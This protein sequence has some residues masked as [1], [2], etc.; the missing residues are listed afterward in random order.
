MNPLRLTVSQ[1]RVAA[2]CP[3][4]AYF[5][6]ELNRTKKL[7]PPSVTRLWKTG[8]D[9]SPET[10]ALG[11]LFH[12]TI[13]RFNREAPRDPRLA[14]ILKGAEGATRLEQELQSLIYRHYLK[15]ESLF[16]AGPKQQ[17]A[18]I[19]VLRTYVSEL[20]A[21][22]AYRLDQQVS[23]S[24]VL[25]QLFGDARRKVDVT[26][27]VGLNGQT[28]N[29]RGVLDYVFFD[30]R[31]NRRRI[32]DYK[33][34]AAN[35]PTS[36]LFQVSLYA[37]M[38]NVQHGTEPDIGVLYLHPHRTMVEKK[39]EGVWADRHKVY[40]FLASLIEWTNYD[41]AKQLG[42]KPPGEPIYCDVCRWKKVCVERLG[43]KSEG[44]RVSDYKQA[45]VGSKVAPAEPQATK[46]ELA[47]PVAET[48][49]DEVLED[50]AAATGAA[51]LSAVAGNEAKGAAS[52]SVC[53]VAPLPSNHLWLGQWQNRP[54]AV[55]LPL[56]ALPT[57]VT[58]V[59]AAGSGKTWLAKVIV[60]EAIRQGVPVI[61]I[62]PQ[63]DLVQFILPREAATFVDQ[64]RLA[65]DEFTRRA[66]PR[67]FTPGTSHGIRI[68]LSP[69]RMASLA[70]LSRI[71]DPKRRQEEFD[72]MLET[73]ASNLVALAEI[74]GE[75]DSQRTFIYK[76][77]RGMPHPPGGEVALGDIV[78]FISAPETAGI[79]EPS[80]IIKNTEREKLARKLT[81][82]IEGPASRLFQGGQRLD[83]A[84]LCRPTAA[85]QAPLNVFYLNAMTDDDQKQFFVA[86]LAAEI[87]R[88]MITSAEPVPGRPSLLFYIDEAR[89]YMPAVGKPPAKMPLIRLFTQGRKYGV[90]CLFCTQSPRSVD[91]NVFGNCSTKIIGR[92]EAAQDV[93]RIAE[94]FTTSGPVPTWVKDRKGAVKG[95]FVA[96]WPEMSSADD[97]QVF[98]SRQLF[99]THEGAWSPDKL[100]LELA[101]RAKG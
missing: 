87:Y 84:E 99:S 53:E 42:L 101:R 22:L 71:A 83:L 90:S 45:S 30:W 73:I 40:N 95:S 6:A 41:P 89:D 75:E 19:R 96:R 29:I 81:S 50:V 3:R 91:Y 80:L 15:Q 100:E 51:G 13:E 31:T 23:V 34:T 17:Q 52:T 9:E 27:H 68:A 25:D 46:Q 63:G 37:L 69:T 78:S 5:D 93:D 43:P 28:I 11:A 21:I 76:L 74:G 64:D 36:D 4:I 55:G 86:S 8:D 88:W 2:S 35:T 70:E 97:G 60:E 57:H 26:F 1:V 49:D 18:F 77:L 44:E 62:D 61:A 7:N 16:E 38:H 56:T 92:M 58:V 47:M 32:I 48:L 82:L 54:T 20:A 39:W 14:E 59:G 85:G 72:G 33:L 94:W 24:D 67:V 65:Y 98:L 12:Q 10:T 66:C 79:D